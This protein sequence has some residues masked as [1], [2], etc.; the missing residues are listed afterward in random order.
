[1]LVI[2]APDSFK[3]SIDAADAAAAM[4]AGVR[5]AVP[6]AEVRE[7]P[8]SDG[9]E[10]FT[11]SVA[12]ALGA[13]TLEVPVRDALGREATGQVAVAGRRAV[14]EVASAVGLGMIASDERDVM[15]ADS[16][17]VGELIRAAL[18]EGADE[19]VVGLGGSA[20]N[21]AGAGMLRVLGARFLDASGAEI[22]TTPRELAHLAEIDV[23]G[24]DPRMAGV[25]V[26]A[27]CDVSNP[28]LGESGASAVFGPQKGATPELVTELDAILARVAEVAGHDGDGGAAHEPGAGAAGGLGYALIGFLGARMRPGVE[29]V[30]E[31]VGLE[32]AVAGA[33][34]VLTGEGSVDAQ[35]LSGK[36][37]AGV[38]AVA[39]R[40]GVPCVVLAG[41]VADDAAV[42]LDH[43]VTALVPIVPGVTDLPTALAEGGA[44]LR[45][46][47][48]TVTRIFAAGRS[49]SASF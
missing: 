14:L 25:E 1:M 37:P 40:A 3:E 48:S 7:L 19:I 9:G 49:G 4:A 21:D 20:T 30:V 2:L 39:A 35:T 43:G 11:E 28:L 18:D 32:E 44:N 6:D 22:G 24:L 23:S 15:G 29:L 42:L 10:G 5:D 31:T 45:R 27:A 46:A 13:R 36:T 16:T 34:L 47:A 38:A 17:G 26:Q 12:V 33:D 41:R 8:V